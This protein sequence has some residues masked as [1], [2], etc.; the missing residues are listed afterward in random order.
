KVEAG[1][2]DAAALRR[3]LQEE[4]GVQVAS[5]RAVFALTHE[6]AERHVELSVWMVDD[7]SG[8]PRGLEGQPLRWEHPAALRDLPLLAADLPIVDWLESGESAVFA[9]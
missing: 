1:E 2:P 7:Y 8:V 4:L 3:E 6:Y 9:S 5:A